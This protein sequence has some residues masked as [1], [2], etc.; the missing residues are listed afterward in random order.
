MTKQKI[1][2]QHYQEVALSGKLYSSLS[3]EE[4][5]RK[6]A[7]ISRSFGYEPEDIDGEANMGLGCGNPLENAKVKAGEV[8]ID[9]GCGKG[10]DSFIAAR[11]VGDQGRVIGI[12]RL[13]E[14]IEK[15]RYISDKRGFKN[16][17]FIQ[18]DITDLPLDDETA[19]IM[20]SNCVINLIEDKQKVCQEI[21][22]VLKK[23][24]R[25]SFSDVVQYQPLPAAIR[26]DDRL[27]A[28]CV[29]GSVPVE[30]VEALL[31]QAGF[32]EITI[33]QEPITDEYANKWGHDLNLKQYIKRAKILAL[34]P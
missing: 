34:K 23:G 1:V 25:L 26:D 12:D 20:I 5:A 19:D 14:M 28:T 16:T 27:H 32:K 24:G 6:I 4:N 3:E 10:M 13:G 8:V 2:D 29:A 31:D 33:I 18:S 15:A 22:R 21:F 30:R 11:A 7:A 17:S 9:L